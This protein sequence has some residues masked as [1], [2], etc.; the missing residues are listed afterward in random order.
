MRR[1][2]YDEIVL[3]HVNN[4]AVYIEI[5]PIGMSNYNPMFDYIQYKVGYLG[6]GKWV[7]TVN[8]IT[9]NLLSRFKED[10]HIKLMIDEILYHR[11]SN[12]AVP[13]GREDF[14]T[15]SGPSKK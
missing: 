14:T 6:G 1:V 9:E 4:I 2:N 7:L 8:I 10:V 13:K 11:V 12:D 5:L 3:A 15:R